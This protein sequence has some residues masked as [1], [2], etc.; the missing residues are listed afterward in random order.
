MTR[1]EVSDLIKSAVDRLKPATEYGRG[2]ISEFNSLNISQPS[3]WFET[4]PMTSELTNQVLPFDAWEINLWCCMLD[5]ET[6]GHKEYEEIIDTCDERAQS[7]MFIL[8]QVVTGYKTITIT[9]ISRTPQIKKS[10]GP[11][12]GVL[13]SFTLNNQDT[14]DQTANCE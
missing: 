6:T 11:V 2:R 9:G 10:D 5:K 1:K 8:N 14:T 12:T 3:V 4:S 7:L 13:L